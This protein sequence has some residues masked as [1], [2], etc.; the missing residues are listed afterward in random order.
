[1]ARN[2]KKPSKIEKEF[3]E[4]PKIVVHKTKGSD[5][6]DNRVQVNSIEEEIEATGKDPREPEPVGGWGK[7]NKKK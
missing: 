2:P 4:Y 3:Q 5:G 6:K 1:M 7:D